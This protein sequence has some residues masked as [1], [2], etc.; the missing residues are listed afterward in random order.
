[1]TA[2]PCFAVS[3]LV[4]QLRA[5]RTHSFGNMCLTYSLAMDSPNAWHAVICLR[6]SGSC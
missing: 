1:V 2:Y 5:S 3:S 6:Q 4:Q